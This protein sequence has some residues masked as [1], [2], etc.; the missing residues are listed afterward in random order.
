MEK[1]TIC[2]QCQ[3]YAKCSWYNGIPVENWDATPT[4][5]HYLRHGKPYTVHSY[6]VH[7][8]PLFVA[9]RLQEVRVDQ[10]A[11]LL[12]I[13]TRTFYR[14]SKNEINERLKE[15]GFKMHIHDLYEEKPSYYLE[16]IG[17]AD[18]SNKG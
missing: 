4:Q 11:A 8:C 13:S 9:D 14:I 16:R 10:I 2:W 15:K 17:G 7:K 12:G 5:I 3:N 6:C 1:E 18:V